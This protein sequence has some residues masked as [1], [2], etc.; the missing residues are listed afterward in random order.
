[1]L[2]TEK[3]RSEYSAV[4]LPIFLPA[5]SLRFERAKSS[6]IK[7]Y[8]AKTLLAL[9]HSLVVITE[10]FYWSYNIKSK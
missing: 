1:M 9:L 4:I 7:I 2:R 3:P 5:D 6:R 10:S 8:A